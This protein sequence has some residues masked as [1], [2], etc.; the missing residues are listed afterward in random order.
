MDFIVG[1]PINSRRHDVIL[2]VVETLTKSI[3][4][5]PVKATYKALGI[6][7]VY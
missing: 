7:K 6:A 4:F 1:I 5:I 3:N 2:V